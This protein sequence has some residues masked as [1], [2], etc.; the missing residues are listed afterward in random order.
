VLLCSRT[1]GFSKCLPWT[2]V[3]EQTEA[4]GIRI[5]MSTLLAASMGMTSHSVQR[6]PAFV[7]HITWYDWLWCWCGIGARNW[8]QRLWCWS[9]GG[10]G[11]PWRK[12]IVTIIAKTFKVSREFTVVLWT[13]MLN[14]I[15]CFSLS[16]ICR[17]IAHPLHKAVDA[18][19]SSRSWLRVAPI[20]ITRKALSTHA[21]TFKGLAAFG[22]W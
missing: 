15:P 2:P 10:C 8:W 14:H 18:L 5:L 20:S 13:I 1:T 6:I 22:L 17:L 9:R 21:Q 7:G 4:T 3:L 11:R 16:P 19:S 12:D